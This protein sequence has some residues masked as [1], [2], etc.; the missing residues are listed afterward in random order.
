MESPKRI[1]FQPLFS[2]GI[3][4]VIGLVAVAQEKPVIDLTVYLCDETE[5]CPSGYKDYDEPGK[6]ECGTLEIKDV[7]ARIVNGGGER[8][9]FKKNIP[10]EIIELPEEFRQ[11]LSAYNQQITNSRGEITSA[12]LSPSERKAILFIFEW[13]EGT[14]APLHLIR[15]A[16]RDERDAM[17]IPPLVNRREVLSKP[18]GR[19]LHHERADSLWHT[20]R[21]VWKLSMLDE[22]TEEPVHTW[23]F[24]TWRVPNQKPAK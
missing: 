12:R 8:I 24:S 9:F 2:S 22:H 5:V 15:T 20:R 10:P 21:V 14:K 13:S 18:H 19:W 4:L 1:S 23:E 11:H 16:H 3:A 7:E 17:F 6:T